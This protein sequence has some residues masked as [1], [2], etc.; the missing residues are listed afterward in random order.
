LC[1]RKDLSGP[2]SLPLSLHYDMLEEKLIPLDDARP[3]DA[4]YRL[5]IDL[6]MNIVRL[7]IYLA[8]RFKKLV[9]VPSGL[10]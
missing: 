7:V 3:F 6:L 1:H 5:Q 9:L 8:F 2:V 4:S 10:G